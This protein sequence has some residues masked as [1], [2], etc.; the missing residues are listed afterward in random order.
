MNDEKAVKQAMDELKAGS[1]DK[2][3]TVSI[4]I[5][6]PEDMKDKL[7]KL[8]RVTG[9]TRSLPHG[10]GLVGNMSWSCG[11]AFEFLFDHLDLYQEVKKEQ[12]E[13]ALA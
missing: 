1:V 3:E 9:H 2:T 10:G 4:T 5:Q 12:L 11:E 8:A 6:L 7:E 13:K